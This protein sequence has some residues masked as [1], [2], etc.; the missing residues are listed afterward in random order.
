METAVD[1]FLA[2][3]LRAGPDLEVMKNGT[4]ESENIAA[5][6]QETEELEEWMIEAIYSDPNV[7]LYEQDPDRQS[8]INKSKGRGYYLLYHNSP[9]PSPQQL[10]QQSYLR[11]SS[12]DQSPTQRVYAEGG[13]AKSGIHSQES[14]RKI[15]LSSTIVNVDNPHLSVLPIRV[16]RTGTCDGDC[17]SYP[18]IALYLRAVQDLYIQQCMNENV[19]ADVAGTTRVPEI[20]ALLDGYRKE[21]HEKTS[22][23]D[24]QLLTVNAAY[25]LSLI[26]KFLKSSWSRSYKHQNGG[27]KTQRLIGAPIDYAIS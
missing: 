24:V 18:T 5:E 15:H 1:E 13:V 23:N 16:N 25:S 8:N 2:A 26:K 11:N 6:L 19:A 3:E 10:L 20:Q 7:V 27:S 9:R 12:K 4:F 22:T 14:S 21:Y 17:P